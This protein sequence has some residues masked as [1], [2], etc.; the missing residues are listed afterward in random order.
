MINNTL[1]YKELII[2][3]DTGFL[4]E[5]LVTH[6]NS[7]FPE[8]EARLKM[9]DGILVLMLKEMDINKLKDYVREQ[10]TTKIK[11]NLLAG[12]LKKVESI[13]SYGLNNGKRNYVDYNKERKV[14]GRKTKEKNRGIYYYAQD[15]PYSKKNNDLPE[16]YKN[17]IICDDSLKVLKK[18]PDNCV[19]MV[20]TSP[21]YN[22]GLEYS[23]N[24]DD[25]Y[26]EKYFDQL[27]AIFDET[28]RVVAGDDA[29]GA[30]EKGVGERR[31]RE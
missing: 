21:P 1:K 25:H 15:H 9:E 14:T 16:A 22:F 23:G 29:G 19:D 5:D 31:V 12:I 2:Q 28:V 4:N 8:K 18:L 26:W 11:Q 13:K 17:K 24:A 27:F 3:E 6:F 10:S 30:L 7:F 20:F